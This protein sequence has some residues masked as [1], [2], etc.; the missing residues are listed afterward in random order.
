[1]RRKIASEPPRVESTPPKGPAGRSW[2]ESETP[3]RTRRQEAQ[4]QR[5][6]ADPSDRRAGR[7]S[8]VSSPARG[9]G[10]EDAEREQRAGCCAGHSLDFQ[11]SSGGS[12]LLEGEELWGM[13]TSSEQAAA[14]ATP[15]TSNS[16]PVTPADPE[17]TAQPCRCIRTRA[18]KPSCTAHDIQ[19]GRVVHPGTFPPSSRAQ[20]A[21]RWG[22]RGRPRRSR[23]S[24]D[25][26]RR[27]AG[28]HSK[29]S[30][31]QRRHSRPET[32][33]AEALE[34]C[35]LSEAKCSLG[36]LELA[37]R[38]HPSRD[39]RGGTATHRS[40]RTSTPYLSLSPHTPSTREHSGVPHHTRE[41]ACV[42]ADTRLAHSEAAKRA[43]YH[44]PFGMHNTRFTHAK[45]SS[46]LEGNPA[47]AS[48]MAR[49]RR[50]ILGRAFP[51][52]GG[53]TPSCSKRPP[54]A[55]SQPRTA[56]REHFGSA[57]PI[58]VTS[59]DLSRYH[60][61]HGSP[62][63]ARSQMGGID[64]NGTHAVANVAASPRARPLGDSR[65]DSFRY[66]PDTP[67]PRFAHAEVGS[68]QKGH[69]NATAAS[70]WTGAPHRGAR[71]SPSRATTSHRRTA[72]RRRRSLAA[73]SQPP[74]GNPTTPFFS[75]SQAAN[76]DH[77][78]AARPPSPPS[79]SLSRPGTP[80]RHSG[81]RAHQP[82]LPPGSGTSPHPLDRARSEG[83]CRESGSRPQDILVCID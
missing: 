4:P 32:A 73:P 55:T 51:I 72:A 33:D 43:L 15:S 61:M 2:S 52:D 8:S 58:P 68:P 76:R 17:A 26:G 80:Q 24:D 64:H 81:R 40:R 75:S 9:G 49:N 69:P 28:T 18:H 5:R 1:M 50:A 45:A 53:T 30:A 22:L 77:A 44:P 14:P 6:R 11:H 47:A 66:L 27:C 79:S 12:T 83:E 65:A 37:T 56:A 23:G 82:L 70:P 13:A 62:S 78:R 10:K 20:S 36:P 34:P 67:D 59:G 57:P 16:P 74:S 31:A 42:A 25:S 71:P 46:P 21:H 60:H 38:P 7:A 19:S 48:S 29:T 35:T 54:A 3:A 63:R 39:R 41:E